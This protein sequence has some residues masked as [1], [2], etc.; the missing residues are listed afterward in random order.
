MIH[1]EF[2]NLAN[3][4]NNTHFTILGLTIAARKYIDAIDHQ[5][6]CGDNH[7]TS[8]FSTCNIGIHEHASNI[9]TIHRNTTIHLQRPITEPSES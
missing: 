7:L 9:T 2:A 4:S 8:N 6:Q 5:L 3:C 1:L